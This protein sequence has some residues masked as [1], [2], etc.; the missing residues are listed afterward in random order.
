MQKVDHEPAFNWLVKQLLRKRDI[1]IAKLRQ[2]GAKKYAKTKTKFVIECPKT[3][4]KTLGMNKKNGN[5]LWAD[6]IKKETKNVRFAFG[7]Q[8]KGDPPP[9][10]HQFIKGH[11]IF[12]VKMEDLRHKVRMVSGSHMTDTSPTIT[13]ATSPPSSH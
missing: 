1:I 3:V 7:I 8:E 12:D 6:A 5:T 2:R 10:G 9:V 11:M 4:D 13:Y